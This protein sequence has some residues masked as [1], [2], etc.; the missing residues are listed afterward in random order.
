MF[1]AASLLACITT[2]MSSANR[3]VN[4]YV[5]IDDTNSTLNQMNADAMKQHKS[6]FSQLQ[7]A[8]GPGMLP[9]CSLE[10]W[11]NQ[12]AVNEWLSMFKQ[13]GVPIVPVVISLSNAT[14]MHQLYKDPTG[15]A[16]QL[17]AIGKMYGFAGFNF[18]YEPQHP[19][20]RDAKSYSAFLKSV[21]DIVVAEGFTMSIWVASWSEALNQYGVLANSGIQFLQDMSTYGGG[22]DIDIT[23]DIYVLKIK[24]ATGSTSQAGLGIGPYHTK[25]WTDT[26]ARR[27]ISHATSKGVVNLDIFRLLMDGVNNWPAP[28]WYPVLQDF[29]DGKI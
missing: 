25:Y 29:L 15:Y 10:G 23:V 12:T 1:K 7:P 19:R 11:K 26:N 16:N 20:D 6:V 14:T 28:F 13:T 9:N 3:T 4:W 24:D 18:D 8:W 27:F 21:N 17:V 2:A 5:S 22:L